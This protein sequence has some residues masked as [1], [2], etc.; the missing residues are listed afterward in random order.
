MGD[1]G[2]DAT[3]SPADPR[4]EARDAVAAWLARVRERG[5]PTVVLGPDAVHD[6]RRLT[7]LLGGD[8]DDLRSQ[9]LLGW[10]HFY[11]FQ[12]LPAG[13]RKPDLDAAITM[14]TP[15][16]MSSVDLDQLPAPLLPVLAQEGTP[17]LGLLM[18]GLSTADLRLVSTLVDMWR[19]VLAATPADHPALGGMAVQPGGGPAGAVPPDRRGNRPGR[20]DRGRA[21]RAG[22]LRRYRAR[23]GH[24]A[25][26]P[27][28]RAA[29]AVPA[30]SCRG[31]PR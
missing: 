11:R 12:V 15:C 29:R 25:V 3:G 31:R 20:G 17:T 4:A 21:R 1:N 18:Q 30:V 27:R 23:P 9:L 16:F 13:Q 28:Q 10:L 8:Q 7:G 14:L 5:D 24:R 22:A 19:R 2:E 26:Q 6:A